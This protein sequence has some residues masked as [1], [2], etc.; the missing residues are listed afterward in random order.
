MMGMCA[1][2]VTLRRHYT[3]LQQTALQLFDWWYA[4][5]RSFALCWPHL[6]Y[7]IVSF[8]CWALWFP[9]SSFAGAIL[10][11]Q[12]RLRWS[13]VHHTC[14]YCRFGNTTSWE[15]LMWL[16]LYHY[17]CLHVLINR[18]SHILTSTCFSALC[19]GCLKL[20]VV[21]HSGL[22]FWQASFSEV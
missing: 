5:C 7:V 16:C 8:A 9:V 21:R 20:P 22:D 3:D 19:T 11:F 1:A 14:L 18:G 17:V 12:A 15:G 2:Y 13:A 4:H 6:N 10:R